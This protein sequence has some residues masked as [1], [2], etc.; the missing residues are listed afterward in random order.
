MIPSPWRSDLNLLLKNLG[1]QVQRYGRS[2]VGEEASDESEMAA[3]AI[4]AR[5]GDRLTLI[6]ENLSNDIFLAKNKPASE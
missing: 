3:A 4:L 1:A 2:V 6:A 5:Y